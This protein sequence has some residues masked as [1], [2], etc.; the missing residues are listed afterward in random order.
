MK[1]AYSTHLS[2]RKGEDVHS[3]SEFVWNL[4]GC[5]DQVSGVFF[6]LLDG[7]GG[8]QTAEYA[9]AH[10]LAHFLHELSA[11]TGG[12]P[13]PNSRTAFD[14]MHCAALSS[15]FKRVDSECQAM[16]DRS[17]STCTVVLVLHEPFSLDGASEHRAFATVANVG[18]SHCYV[19]QSSQLT[20]VNEDH[21]A[22][23]NKHENARIEASEGWE[24]SRKADAKGPLR[25]FPGGLMMTRS[26][27]DAEAGAGCLGEPS[28]TRLCTSTA[29]VVLASDGLW[30]ALGMKDISKLTLGKLDNEQCCKHLVQLASKREGKKFGDDV[31]VTVIDLGP[32]ANQNEPTNAL[33]VWKPEN[34][35]PDAVKVL[36]AMRNRLGY[37]PVPGPELPPLGTEVVL[38]GQQDVFPHHRIVQYDFGFELVQL[39]GAG[40]RWIAVDRIAPVVVVVVEEPVEKV[41]EEPVEKVDEQLHPETDIGEAPHETKKKKKTCVCSPLPPPPPAP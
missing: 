35:T 27:G 9:N 36:S 5:K 41:E 7:H 25:L 11:V 13:F 4:A 1:L 21:R 12:E 34:G 10:L 38:D 16:F 37:V 39:S 24:L 14:E 19:A 40:K 26:L 30:D 2:K 17:G 29:R 23:A 32:F 28:I 3:E 8:V 20:R 31:T 33:W 6:A 15:A 22:G 18:D